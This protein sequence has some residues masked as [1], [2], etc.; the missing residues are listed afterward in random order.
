ME[1]LVAMILLSPV[2][3]LVGLFT[4]PLMLFTSRFLVRK[5]QP[6]FVKQQQD[7][8]KFKWLY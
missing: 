8:G 1:C 2:L 6:F 4:M 5:T 7:L 3:T